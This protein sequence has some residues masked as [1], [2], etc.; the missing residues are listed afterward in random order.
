MV[1]THA[2]GSV[3]ALGMAPAI[4]HSGMPFDA[5]FERFLR[6]AVNESFPAAMANAMATRK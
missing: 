2:Y 5:D 6:A 3:T 4:T 1:P